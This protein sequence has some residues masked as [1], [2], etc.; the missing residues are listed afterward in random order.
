M[1]KIE[2]SRKTKGMTSF[3][4]RLAEKISRRSCEAGKEAAMPR[5]RKT[6][7]GSAR[8]T[9]LRTQREVLREVMVSARACGAWLT[10]HEVASLAHYGEA[11]NPGQLGQL[12]K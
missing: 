2:M 7:K 5:T 6:R 8:R 12:R 4:K 3:L 10:L 11:S 1:K 9:V